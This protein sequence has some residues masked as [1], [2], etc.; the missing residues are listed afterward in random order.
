[1]NLEMFKHKIDLKVIYPTTPIYTIDRPIKEISTTVKV[2]NIK[3]IIATLGPRG[4][5]HPIGWSDRS[6]IIFYLH[7]IS[8][9][10]SCHI[11]LNRAFMGLQGV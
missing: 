3:N 10:S 2:E 11:D 6:G 7:T 5:I 1:M 9:C 8:P 4:K